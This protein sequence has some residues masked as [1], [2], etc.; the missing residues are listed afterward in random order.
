M[1]RLHSRLLLSVTAKGPPLILLFPLHRQESVA[2][3]HWCYRLIPPEGRSFDPILRRTIL[4]AD[5]TLP[6]GTTTPFAGASGTQ[7]PCVKAS[8]FCLVGCTHDDG[9]AIRKNDHFRIVGLKT[10]HQAASHN[11]PRLFQTRAERPQIQ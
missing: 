3:T 1:K 11:S 7:I 8:R 2:S 10:Q 4:N 9:P 5:K 6:G